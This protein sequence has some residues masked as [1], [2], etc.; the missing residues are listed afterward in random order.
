M[1]LAPSG[2]ERSI[3]QIHEEDYEGLEI[4]T[5]RRSRHDP[6]SLPLATLKS[7]YGESSA[8]GEVVKADIKSSPNKFIV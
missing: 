1:E 2:V 8:P 4:A 7:I 5:L 3:Q 6:A